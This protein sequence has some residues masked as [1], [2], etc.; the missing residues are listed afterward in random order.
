MANTYSLSLVTAVLEGAATERTKTTTGTGSLTE[1]FWT[2]ITV[3]ALASDDSIQLGS[4]TD[5]VVVIVIGA[6]GISFKLG[7]T[8]ADAIGAN[9]VAV[10]SDEDGLGIDE[11]R[12]S[13]ADAAPHAVTVIAWE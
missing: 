8:G 6:D 3:A 4:L 5:P 7:D 13:N 9:P 12:V 1:E 2:T 10:V 11:V